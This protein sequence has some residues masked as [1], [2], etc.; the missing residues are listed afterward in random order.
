M[1]DDGLVLERYRRIGVLGQGGFGQTWLCEDTSTGQEVVLK[2]LDMRRT[3]DWKSVELFEREAQVLRGLN[4]P[5]IPKY[6]ADF[7]VERDGESELYLV[8]ERAPGKNLERWIEDG[9]WR[10]DFDEIT[11]LARELLKVLI[12]LHQLAPP[13]IHRDLKP[14]NIMRA[15]DGRISVV[16]FGAVKSTWQEQ[17]RGSTVA[18]T[19][20][21]MAPEQL[22]GVGLPQTDLYGLG[23]TLLYVIARADPSSLPSKGLAIDF[24]A[25]LTVPEPLASWLERCLEADYSARFAHALEALEA[26]ESGHVVRFEPPPALEEPWVAPDPLTLEITEPYQPKPGQLRQEPTD[27]AQERAAF[28]VQS[29]L[30]SLLLLIVLVVMGFL[31]W[32][33]T[34]YEVLEWLG[35]ALIPIGVMCWAMT[36][37]VT[38]ANPRSL[39]A[40]NRGFTLVSWLASVLTFAL[41][42]KGSMSGLMG[43]YIP[44]SLLTILFVV[45]GGVFWKDWRESKD[46]VKFELSSGLKTHVIIDNQLVGFKLHDHEP[47]RRVIFG[48]T[49]DRFGRIFLGWGLIA[50]L[51]PLLTYFFGAGWHLWWIVVGA[52]GVLLGLVGVMSE[53]AEDMKRCTVELDDDDGRTILVSSPPEEGSERV[54]AAFSR[55]R[56]MREV[57]EG[58]KLE[59]SDSVALE[60]LGLVDGQERVIWAYKGLDPERAQVMKMTLRELILQVSPYAFGDE[61]GQA[62]AVIFG[63]D[64]LGQAEAQV[65]EPAIAQGAGSSW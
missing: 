46:M 56:L 31:G 30:W 21:Y 3:Q 26:L 62:E 58:E 14:L 16:D 28:H 59:D 15:P 8:Q 53:P 22:R 39:L 48:K 57:D 60:V 25:V 52:I 44:A 34:G 40:N 41:T 7:R 18:G 10:P 6:L 55:V 49:T 17:G 42:L 47:G 12:Y 45:L 9:D 35:G 33:S 63:D 11:Q 37:T 4:H 23:A 65:E 43:A 1:G 2:Q 19:F 38:L 24:R 64:E 32:Q 61:L 51:Y 20:G 54:R 36:P 5:S 27:K 50:W 29:K 13:V